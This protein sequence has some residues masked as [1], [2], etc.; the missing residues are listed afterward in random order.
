MAAAGQVLARCLRLLR[1]KARPGVTTAAL[2]KAAERFIRSQGESPPSRATA[3][4]RARSAPRPTRWWST[5]SPAPTSSRRGDIL[6]IDV[7]VI[8]DGW[9][10]DAAITVPVGNVTP[11]PRS[12][13]PP[14]ARP[15]SRPSSS[16]GPETGSATSP[17]PS[18]P[19]W[20]PMDS[21]SSG[22]SWA[23]GSAARCT[24][25]RRSPTSAS[26]ASAP[27]SRRAWSWPSSRWSTW[28]APD[29]GGRRQLVRLLAGRVAG[30]PL[31]AHRG[32]HGRGA[33]HPHPLAP[34]GGSPGRLI[35]ALGA[36]A[37]GGLL[38]IFRG[39]TR[40]VADSWASCR[41]SRIKE[42]LRNREGPSVGQAHVR[43]V[44]D[45][46]PPRRGP[47]DL[48]EPAP[49]AAPGLGHGAQSQES[50]FRSTSG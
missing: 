7:G 9:V 37:G 44:Q 34:R 41:F 23:T 21:R 22:P 42:V 6:S 49:Q 12:C 39:C 31:R 14:P 16:A 40:R 38:L 47:R 20:R 30:G 15:S 35:A 4:F 46:P 43:E 25:T 13:S 24:R 45:H 36:R 2:D 28:A 10:A 26:R 11:S 32:G 50:T 27:S 5:G 3:A 18:R 8:L 29:P 17:T 19:A 1:G 33:P 48:P